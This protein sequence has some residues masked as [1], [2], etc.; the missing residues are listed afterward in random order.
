LVGILAA[1]TFIAAVVFFSGVWIASASGHDFFWHHGY[2]DSG[3]MG[4]GG[5]MGPGQ[6]TPSPAPT[7]P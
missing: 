7:R 3:Q 2:S 6:M 4:S 5:M 1:V